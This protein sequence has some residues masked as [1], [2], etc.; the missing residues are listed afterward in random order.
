MVTAQ[1]PFKRISVLDVAT[2]FEASSGLVP[3]EVGS[4]P[5]WS[6]HD[7]VIHGGARLCGWPCLSEA[8]KA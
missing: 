7:Q 2:S 4:P 8:G 3:T 5:P 1:P 6:Y